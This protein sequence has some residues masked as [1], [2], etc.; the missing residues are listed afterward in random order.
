MPTQPALRA[1]TPDD[2]PAMIAL[3]REMAEYERLDKHFSATP[4]RLAAALFGAPPDIFAVLAERE[5]RAVG[6]G[7]WT[8]SF[9]TFQ[10]ERD[11]FVEDIFVTRS[12]RRSGLGLTLMRHMAREA[13]RQGCRKMVWHVLPDNAPALAFYAKLGAT[14][15]HVRWVNREL[16][17]QALVALAAEGDA[18]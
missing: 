6:L 18:G 11:L 3:L 4:D 8:F 9:R 5:G 1:P 16:S 13:R 17:G 15:P 2:A 7:V 14:L 10:C 12:E